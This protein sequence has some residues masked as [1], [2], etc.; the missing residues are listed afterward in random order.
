MLAWVGWSK[1]ETDQPEKNHCGL[2]LWPDALPDA[3]QSSFW[4]WTSDDQV[5]TFSNGHP[6]VYMVAYSFT[7]HDRMEG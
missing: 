4:L 2:F 7:D 6:T 1:S 5:C 3:N